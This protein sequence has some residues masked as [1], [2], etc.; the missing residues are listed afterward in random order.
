MKLAPRTARALV[1][2]LALLPLAMFAFG[3]G[4]RDFASPQALLNMLGRA[5]GVFGLSLLLVAAALSA[6][7]PGFDQPFGGLTKLWRTH[8]LLGAAALLVLLAHPVLLA[9]AS[10]AHGHHLAV[11]TL[12]PPLDYQA[13]WTTWATWVG[14]LALLLMIIFLA[15]SFAFFGPPNYERWKRIHAL[16]GP[17]VVFALVHT[18]LF[19]RT[20]PAQLDVVIWSV[21]A[22]L[23]LAAVAWRFVFSRRV[24]R[25]AY[26]IVDVDRVANNVVEVS[27]AP[28]RRSL[29]YQAGNFVYLTPLDRSLAAGHGEEHPYTLSS[30][31]EEDHLRIAIKDLG[32]ASRAL[33]TIEPGARVTVEGP[34]GRFFPPGRPYDSP[35]LWVAGGIGITPF[36]AR[37]RHLAQ[38]GQRVD[39]VLVYCVQDEARALFDAELRELAGRI[40]GFVLEYHYFYQEG[41][42]DS[43]FLNTSCPD[44]TGREVFVCG[45]EPLNRRLLEHTRDAGILSER[46]HTEDFQLL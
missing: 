45:P 43:D 40:D 36:L 29:K 27:L 15:P 11:A 35:E 38:R 46:I 41:P 42:I 6:R 4:G 33:Q 9:L 19:S 13:T 16:A 12:F 37:L 28:E 24:G 32:D 14:W 18:W 44:L 8:H 25:L 22:L 7:V 23:T 21:F 39:I 1:W 20:M 26:R 10:A 2:G 17:T 3:L 31:P 5:A 34:Y 30:A